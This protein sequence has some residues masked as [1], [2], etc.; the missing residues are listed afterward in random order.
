M[1]TPTDRKLFLKTTTKKQHNI[2][3]YCSTCGIKLDFDR[4][5]EYPLTCWNCMIVNMDSLSTGR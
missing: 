5:S 1:A 2:N 4:I 3:C